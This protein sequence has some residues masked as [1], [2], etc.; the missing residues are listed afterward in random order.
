MALAKLKICDLETTLST[1]DADGMRLYALPSWHPMR[2]IFMKRLRLMLQLFDGY[3][4]FKDLLEVGFGC[5]VLVPELESR[6]RRYT[7]IDIHE[8]VGTVRRSLGYAG[9]ERVKFCTTDVCNLPFKTASFDCV[10]SMSVLEH[11]CE[12]DKAVSELY[13]ILKPGGIL[14]VGFPIENF[15][16][17]FILD[18]VKKMIGFDRKLHHPT[19]HKQIIDNLSR[20]M[21]LIKDNPYPF[22]GSV[23]LSLFYT[24]IWSKS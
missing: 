1:S 23:D 3:S 15:A 11:I 21:M 22:S 24:G 9:N 5:G 20:R 8:H 10:F 18:I 17:N 16:S 14:L 4:E 12:I 13:R 2:M 6:C 19:N 7:G